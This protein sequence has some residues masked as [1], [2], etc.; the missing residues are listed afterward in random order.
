MRYNKAYESKPRILRDSE[1]PKRIIS[2]SLRA[3]GERPRDDPF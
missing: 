3:R 2:R 1:E